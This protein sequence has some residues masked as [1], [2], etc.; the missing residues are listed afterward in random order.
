[1]PVNLIELYD[2]IEAGSVR[3]KN[4]QRSTIKH[5]EV[6]LF[7]QLLENTYRLQS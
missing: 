5:R 4:G 2:Q 1:M 7:K 6:D 3:Y